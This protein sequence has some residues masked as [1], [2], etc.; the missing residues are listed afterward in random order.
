MASWRV[1]KKLFVG[2][3]PLRKADLAALGDEA[4]KG[5]ILGVR[6]VDLEMK[7]VPFASD[8]RIFFATPHF[9]GQARRGGLRA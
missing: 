4:P 5:P 3:R 6:T 9:D 8:P 2:E 1:N 7:D